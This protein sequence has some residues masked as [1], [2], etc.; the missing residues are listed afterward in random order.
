MRKLKIFGSRARGD[1]RQTSDIDLAIWGG[2]TSLFVIEVDEKVNT[3]LKYDLVDME[4][5]VQKELEEVINV[6]GVIIYEE[7]D[8]FKR[9]LNNLYDINE[10]S[11]P[12]NNVI[13]TGLVGLY[14]ICFEQS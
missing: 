9:A 4:K 13:L 2:Q 12:Y 7:V 11:E 3:L 10:Y 5:P 6:E 8:N 14:E 1:Y